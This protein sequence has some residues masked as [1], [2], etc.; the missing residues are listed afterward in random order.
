[1]MGDYWF[2]QSCYTEWKTEFDK[3]LHSKTG[4]HACKYF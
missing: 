3:C 4:H 1:M 2:C